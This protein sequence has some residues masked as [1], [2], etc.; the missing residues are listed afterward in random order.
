MADSTEYSAWTS[1]INSVRTPLG[2][3]A[4][5]VLVLDAVLLGASAT[6]AIV[7]MWAPVI[8]L[9]LLIAG[10]FA[11]VYLN[12]L[13]LYHPSDW[14]R[15]RDVTLLFFEVTKEDWREKEKKMPQPLAAYMVDLDAEQCKMV[16]RR[17]GHKE[18]VGAHVAPGASDWVVQLP[19][20]VIDTDRVDLELVERSGRKWRTAAF[21]VYGRQV[22]AF[23]QAAD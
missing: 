11:M 23:V 8:L 17:K 22:L 9:A 21:Q 16:I 18:T 19:A 12:P 6:A 10:V 5:V 20:D 7:P 4:L 13:A 14:P 2:F 1:I 15:T 3:F